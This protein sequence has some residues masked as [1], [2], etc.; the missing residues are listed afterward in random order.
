EGLAEAEMAVGDEGAHAG[1]L[2]ERHRLAIALVGH[3]DFG[4][5]TAQRDL[6]EQTERSRLVAS[7]MAL[8]REGKGP[9]GA[10]ESI[11]DSIGQEMGLS[12]VDLMEHM[13]PL[14]FEGFSL[15]LRL[16]QEGHALGDSPGERI[17]VAQEAHRD[18]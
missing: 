2:G 17:G 1:K 14:Q 13:G 6:A 7:L 18:R 10:S 16:L 9:L 15:S 12:Q 11:A 5:I 4:G 8:A 3:L